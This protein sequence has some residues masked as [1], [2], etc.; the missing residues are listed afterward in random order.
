MATVMTRIAP[1]AG[2][3][4]PEKAGY[5]HAVWDAALG[6]D[7]LPPDGKILILPSSEGAEIEVAISHGVDEERII[8]VDRSAAVIATSQWRKA[9][10][11]IRF[12]ACD[13]GTV[14]RKLDASCDLIGFANL[15]LCGQVSAET[16][17]Q[18]KT[19]LDTCPFHN[20]FKLAITVAKGRE[21]AALA[22][23]M[24][25]AKIGNVQA[26]CDRIRALLAMVGLT[27]EINRTVR[28]V[29]EGSY[30]S[31]R[32]PMTW[33][34][35]EICTF[36]VDALVV[37]GGDV[38]SCLSDIRARFEGVYEDGEL[39]V[40]RGCEQNSSLRDAVWELGETLDDGGLLRA[41]P[42]LLQRIFDETINLIGYDDDDDV[43]EHSYSKIRRMCAVEIVRRRRNLDSNGCGDGV[44]DCA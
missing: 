15:D 41:S 29:A 20:E 31:G 33:V 40:V 26:S 2:Y 21:G 22:Q 28:V 8:C 38:Y 24:R 36:D 42:R 10:P 16:V 6:N 27:N 13:I 5:R 37:S 1:S 17:D 19:F 44:R 4:T 12:H 43:G 3:A 9:R 11:N 23:L 18:I 7:G 35:L 14:G 25:R 39:T 30:V 34:V 32:H